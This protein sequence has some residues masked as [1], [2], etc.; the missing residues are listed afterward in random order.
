MTDENVQWLE[1]AKDA[2]NIGIAEGQY[3]ICAS[4]IQKVRDEGFD[5]EAKELDRLLKEETIGTFL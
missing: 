3:V 1:A 4:F 2:F 5:V